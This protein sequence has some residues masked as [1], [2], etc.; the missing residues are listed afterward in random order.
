MADEKTSSDVDHVK[1][2]VFIEKV[3][4]L[5]ENTF[6]AWGFDEKNGGLAPI[7]DTQATARHNEPTT[8]RRINGNFIRTDKGVWA[9]IWVKLSPDKPI[10]HS[11]VFAK[12]PTR[13]GAIL[14]EIDDSIMVGSPDGDDSDLFQKALLAHFERMA[15]KQH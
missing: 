2:S 3:I 8:Q 12:N 15:D 10:T 7:D 4:N 14:I 1:D 9:R 11:I 5:L 13:G 6:K